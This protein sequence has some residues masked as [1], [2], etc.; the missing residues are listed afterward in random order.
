[1]NIAVFFLM[2]ERSQSRS[3]G[4][5]W[6]ALFLCAVSFTF[7]CSKSDTA[8]SRDVERASLAAATIP[9]PAPASI[10]PSA[11]PKPL[12]AAER[13]V[14]I[15]RLLARPLT[16]TPESADERTLLRAER[17]ALIS[18][19]QV[20]FQSGSQLT[21]EAVQPN[22]APTEQHSATAASGDQIVIATNSQATSLPFLEQLTPT[23]RDHYFQ[24]LWL[25]NGNFVEVNHNGFGFGRFRV[26]H[27]GL[28]MRPP[29]RA[30]VANQ[31]RHRG[32]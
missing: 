22:S 18:S 10:A 32:N 13:M 3:P 25:Q 31:P 5:I 21:G 20:P 26:N 15:D 11:T 29:G 23:E 9:A 6:V 2:S 24:E 27:R 8:T 16:G 19:G 14:E 17:A 12:T 30:R 4:S 1:M 28:H 7:G